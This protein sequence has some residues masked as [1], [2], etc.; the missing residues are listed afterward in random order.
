MAA[1]MLAPPSQPTPPLTTLFE[2]FPDTTNNHF[3]D[4]YPELMSAFNIG[5]N[6]SSLADIRDLIAEATTQQKAVCFV[7]LVDDKLQLFL[8]P[9][10]INSALGVPD[11]PYL[12]GK[13]FAFQGNVVKGVGSLVHI[14]D[15]W[16][17][18]T[19]SIV[20]PTVAS[21]RAL[22]ASDTNPAITFSLTLLELLTPKK[23][24]HGR[25]VPSPPSM[26]ATSCP[27]TME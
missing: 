8:L 11:D 12:T 26:Q 4:H 16:F 22:M 15:N 19:T 10:R 27:K 17:N 20:V 9:F 24:V 25:C 7:A 3:L 14:P 23:Y 18:L 2:H 13:L 1:A 5:A 6:P 21:S